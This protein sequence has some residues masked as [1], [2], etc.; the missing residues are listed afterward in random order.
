MFTTIAILLTQLINTSA[1]IAQ[2]KPLPQFFT[3][4]KDSPA[5][6]MNPGQMKIK[7]SKKKR[8]ITMDAVYLSEGISFSSIKK[9]V[10]EIDQYDEISVPGIEESKSVKD[11]IFW[12][13]SETMGVH[14]RDYFDLKE[15]INLEKGF[16]LGLSWIPIKKENEWKD[17]IDTSFNDFAG[18]FY[19]K[20]LPREETKPQM[21]YIR[22]ALVF[23]LH[24][25]VPP[26][27]IKAIVDFKG[28]SLAE[29]YI[30]AII[31][32]A[33]KSEEKNVDRKKTP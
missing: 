15:F 11:S 2:E 1:V 8:K 6:S 22:Y 18:Y 25:V 16:A 14:S 9:A 3:E 31:K 12:M 17:P 21:N 24:T 33:I 4:S 19:I 29:G 13:H 5:S 10:S 27:V 20:S 23:D 26:F 32:A 30:D 7:I 28:K